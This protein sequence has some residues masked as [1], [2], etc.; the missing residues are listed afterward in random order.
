LAQSLGAGSQGVRILYAIVATANLAFGVY[1][2]FALHGEQQA[3]GAFSATFGALVL[4]LLFNHRAEE[5][6]ESRHA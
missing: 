6:F 2:L 5:F 3:T 1:A 4:Y